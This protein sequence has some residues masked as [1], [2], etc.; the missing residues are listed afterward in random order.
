MALDLE[1]LAKPKQF[2]VPVRGGAFLLD[3]KPYRIKADDGWWIVEIKNNRVKAI[4]QANADDTLSARSIYGFTHHN[5]IIFQNFDVARRKFGLGLQSPLHFNQS[6]TFEAIRAVVWEDG[7]VY[8]AEPN[9]AEV[10]IFNLKDLLEDDQTLEGVKG[11]TPEL[12]TVF[13]NHALE[14]E[15]IKQALEAAK[16]KED[17]ERMMRDIPYRLQ[18]T[19]QRAGAEMV[20]FSISGKRIIVDWKEQGSDTRYNSVIDAETWM[21]IEA[22]YCMSGDDK[23]HNISSMVKTAQIYQEQHKHVNI[24][25]FHGDDELVRGPH[26]EREIQDIDDDEDW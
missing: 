25:R 24:T 19:F 26:L 14:K 6:Q 12:R 1:A 23:R 10:N 16:R 5:Q 2:I 9:Y 15:A 18:H 21:V 22:G 4:E 7:E 3:N 8:W 17:H 13:L 11:I 20:N